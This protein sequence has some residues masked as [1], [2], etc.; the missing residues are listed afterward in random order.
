MKT[1]E[2]PVKVRITKDGVE[3]VLEQ[4]STIQIIEP[5]PEMTI[6]MFVTRPD[7]TFEPYA[8]PYQESENIRMNVQVRLKDPTQV[9]DRIVI[10]APVYDPVTKTV[11]IQKVLDYGPFTGPSDLGVHYDWNAGFPIVDW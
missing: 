3:T 6:K 10:E 8:G 4:K 11:Q 9:A 2:I 5:A 7:G 1:Q